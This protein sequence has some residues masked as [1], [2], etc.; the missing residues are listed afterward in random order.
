M[1]IFQTIWVP[2]WGSNQHLFCFLSPLRL[3]AF[4]HPCT[5]M[6]MRKSILWT[7]NATL[8]H[9]PSLFQ[10]FVVIKNDGK[11][12]RLRRRGFTLLSVNKMLAHM[13]KKP[14]AAP[15]FCILWSFDTAAQKKWKDIL[16]YV[17]WFSLACIHF[18]SCKQTLVWKFMCDWICKKVKWILF[19]QEFLP[20]SAK[21]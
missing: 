16:G 18:Q 12:R 15:N 2:M 6:S 10:P 9:S 1:E 19:L 17:F 8:L 3:Q 14:S 21:D 20:N 5:R 7:R 13:E 4:T 11:K